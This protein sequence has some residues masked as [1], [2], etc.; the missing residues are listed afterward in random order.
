M[1]SSLPNP[2]DI[3]AW[4]RLATG[5][6]HRR[7]IDRAIALLTVAIQLNPQAGRLFGCRAQMFQFK[8]DYLRALE[9]INKAIQFEPSRSGWYIK[10]A[11]FH[12][13]GWRNY[14]SAIEDATE[15]IRL[16]PKSPVAHF[17]RAMCYLDQ[18]R[19]D[20][21]IADCDAATRL[22]S[23]LWCAY[24]WRGHAFLRKREYARA[25]ADWNEAIWLENK[26]FPAIPY[27]RMVSYSG[28]AQS[29]YERGLYPEVIRACNKALQLSNQFAF[30]YYFR[31]LAESA[32][33][34]FER[35]VPD[36][37][38]AIEIRHDYARALYARAQCYDAL[39]DFDR[40][41]ADRRNASRM[42]SQANRHGP[43]EGL[44]P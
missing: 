12:Y 11:E 24:A 38:R 21:A 3:D 16:N 19:V 42:P 35:A 34:N 4:I 30:A 31:G 8:G 44:V 2:S 13:Y 5:Y 15:G 20:D 28:L 18:G 6:S 9:D 7:D 26:R 27:W 25:Q 1:S 40:A 32:L 41:E 33:L 22:D 39:G 37:S 17:Y 23:D 10:R 36:F 43:T 14:N 29:Y